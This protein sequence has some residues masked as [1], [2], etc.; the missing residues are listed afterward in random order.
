MTRLKRLLDRVGAWLEQIGRRWLDRA[1]TE[2]F[3]QARFAGSRPEAMAAGGGKSALAATRAK[4][5]SGGVLQRWLRASADV[6]AEA[7]SQ[8][9]RPGHGPYVGLW[10]EGGGSSW[11]YEPM[12][13]E[14]DGHLLMLAPSRSGKSRDVLVTS[15]LTNR[16]SAFV[17]DIKGENYD[18]TAGYRAAHG[19][20]VYAFSP[21]DEDAR[22][23]RWNPLTA[24]RSSPLHRVGD[25][26]TIGQVF[27]P[28]DGG[29]TSS[30]AF[31]NDQA[32]NLF[33]GLGLVLL[34]TP[35]LPRT[36]GEMLRQSSGKG[37]SL[38]DHLSGLI[39]QRRGAREPQPGQQAPAVKVVARITNNLALKKLRVNQI[40]DVEQPVL[41]VTVS[42]PGASP[43]TV[44]REIVD[45]IEKA[46]Q[47]I[48]G[49]YEVRSTAKES[50]AT[51]TMIFN[52]DK[53]VIEA[54][55][56]VRNAIGT[57]RHKLPVEMREPVITRVD[58]AAQPIMQLA[59]SS[60][61]QSLAEI[62]RLAEDQLADRFRA[63]PGV[64]QVTA[65]VLAPSQAQRMMQ[66]MGDAFSSGS[67]AE[68]QA[69]AGIDKNCRLIKGQV[70][71]WK[72]NQAWE[73]LWDVNGE[74]TP[75]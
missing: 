69:I 37:R 14:G 68:M 20:A 35:S 19:Q 52:F 56:E 3:G 30:E 32:R 34:E 54:A 44:E 74:I 26:L 46:L 8:E 9:I 13:Y 41:V 28:N 23:H 33:L 73:D 6:L 5:R 4:L 2:T 72:P 15:L 16:D 42:Y 63:I 1:T 36:I 64:A 12:R 70:F 53:N 21:F 45:R 31:F 71:L 62:S 40:P 59:L 61:T 29:G 50:V 66:A 17:L 38:K 43:E 51:L 48:S 60:T 11:R 10:S 57:V 75:A 47:G 25:L 22:S 39:T 67:E 49:V 27:F 7:G 55:D 18:I 58:P 65:A 24:V